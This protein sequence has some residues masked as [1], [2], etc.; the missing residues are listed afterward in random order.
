MQ[1]LNLRRAC[2]LGEPKGC[3][4]FG[5]GL[6]Q[7]PRVAGKRILKFLRKGCEGGDADGCYVLSK[8]QV[9]NRVPGGADSAFR[10]SYSACRMGQVQAC[11]QTGLM[12]LQGVGCT[13]DVGKGL[14]VLVNTCNQLEHGTSCLKAAQVIANLA[15]NGIHV[16]PGTG[17][18][19]RTLP[20]Q[21]ARAG[22][23]AHASGQG[24]AFMH[25]VRVRTRPHAGDDEAAT[26]RKT[27]EMLRTLLRKGCAFKNEDACKELADFEAQFPAPAPV[28]S[29]EEGDKD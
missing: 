1:F 4:I 25:D 28:A 22:L 18:H 17:V 2:E 21:F 7:D 11:T 9:L 13:Q 14:T 23:H 29:G 19:A 15:D 3:T 6:S 10:N 5:A 24:V 27:Q 20:R 8:L 16:N 26:A 12:F